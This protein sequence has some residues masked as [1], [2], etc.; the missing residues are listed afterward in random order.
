MEWE[1]LSSRVCVQGSFWAN[2][3]R[4]DDTEQKETPVTA[5]LPEARAV[6]GP[7]HVLLGSLRGV[8]HSGQSS[9]PVSPHLR[10]ALQRY[11]ARHVFSPSSPTQQGVR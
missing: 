9:R 5:G 11:P 10:V 3:G 4:D 7:P 2:D 8:T 6:H 1:D